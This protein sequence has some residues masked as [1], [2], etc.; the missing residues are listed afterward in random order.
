MIDQNSVSLLLLS[1][2]SPV[3]EEIKRA[4]AELN[5]LKQTPGFAFTLLSLCGNGNAQAEQQT[6]HVAKAAA[7]LFKN[8]IRINWDH[9]ATLE[10]GQQPEAVINDDEKRRIKDG[11]VDF[12]CSVHPSVQKQLSEAVR[13]IAFV[14]WPQMW[15]NLL[16][17][18]VARLDP[19]LPL[20]VLIGVLSTM[21]EIFKRFRDAPA[22][23]DLWRELKVALEG[24]QEPLLR[25]FTAWL[26]PTALK[27]N[28]QT[29]AEQYY[30]AVRLC[31]RVFYSLNWQTIPEHFEDHQELWMAQFMQFLILPDDPF[32]DFRDDENS[33]PQ[34]RVRTAIFENVRL[35]AEKYSAEF[36]PYAAHFLQA[37]FSL[38]VKASQSPSTRFDEM[39][40]SGMRYVSTI[41]SSISNVHMFKDEGTMKGILEQVVIPN[42]AIRK[43]DVEAFDDNPLEYLKRDIEGSDAETRR[44]IACDMIEKLCVN[45]ANEVSVLGSNYV[46]GL[47]ERQ[48]SNPGDWG[49]KD[50]AITLFIAIVVEKST[51]RDGATQIKNEQSMMNFLQTEILPEL[52]AQ[53]SNTPIL[54]A[55]A[56]KFLA[57]FRQFLPKEMVKSQ[58]F[59]L[60]LT[61][62]EAKSV[63]LHT[64]AAAAIDGFLGIRELPNA[65]TGIKEMRFKREDIASLVQPL[66]QKLFT[67]I[68]MAGVNYNEFV[69][70]CVVRVISVSREDIGPVVPSI[71]QKLSQTLQRV[72][73]APSNPT[74]NHYMFECIAAV[75]KFGAESKMCTLDQLEQAI[76][77][78]LLKI[79]QV[80]IIEFVPYAL[81]ILAQM[82]FM[83]DSSA[84][85]P[86]M[87][88]MIFN[89]I[90]S[91]Q[92]WEH[93]GSIPALVY[94]IEAILM[95]GMMSSDEGKLAQLGT[96]FEKLLA[97]K[98]T[99]DLSFELMRCIV[100]FANFEM[101]RPKL[102]GVF[103]AAFMRYSQKRL[104]TPALA[105]S[106]ITFSCVLIGKHGPQVFFDAIESL[107]PGTFHKFLT[108]IFLIHFSHVTGPTN[109]KLCSIGLTRLLCEFTGA[110]DE[111]VWDQLIMLQVQLLSDK[112]QVKSLQAE[113]A[114]IVGALEMM[115]EVGHDT[116][117]ARLSFARDSSQDD[118]F[119]E[120]VDP[121]RFF[122]ERLGG[123][124]QLLHRA[125]HA[126]QTNKAAV[127]LKLPDV[128]ASW[129]RA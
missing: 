26:S 103:Q 19:S 36:E 83:H 117:F 90:M 100:C 78:T 2:L 1:T 65:Q 102:P 37:A 85:T 61:N 80:Y 67:L 6:L 88:L 46:S 35:Y 53:Q 55:D 63:V 48:R 70:K 28:S 15:E 114:E 79:L 50:A 104:R 8:F 76:I 94:Y 64:Y 30:E 16:P 40:I 73:A 52:H 75:I 91:P 82:L 126:L 10:N 29:G 57:V 43:H 112:A 77:Q 89:A 122:V 21:N 120:I 25:F 3:A 105:T 47:L 116:S 66:F 34:E 96:T 27:S 54:K 97:M 124:A 58:I 17:S 125:V 31:C 56:I 12:M 106:L 123:N 115:E 42:L 86:D 9:E 14:D 74:F 51:Q 71:L 111:Q 49:A 129:T 110:M 33:G 95:R 81:Q 18:L 93:R 23:D 59:P 7:I 39:V 4:E 45:F 107:V 32:P 13:I 87:Y 92:V 121:I 118:I 119:K 41:V 68:D 38:L 128:F 11:M 20:P 109:K 22:E 108:E 62:M 72:A 5:K 101:V 69:M 84:K 113:K 99:E 98:A 24:C 127:D 60:L 44:R